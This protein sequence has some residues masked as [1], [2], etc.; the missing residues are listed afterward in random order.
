MEPNEKLLALRIKEGDPTAFEE[1]YSTNYGILHSYILTIIENHFFVEDIIEDVFVTLWEKRSDLEINTSLK[2]YLF[3]I[4]RN[5]C[6]DFIRKRK[7]REEYKSR[8][9]K[10]YIIESNY[11]PFTSEISQDDKNSE[12][13]RVIRS[14]ID[15]L[16]PKCRK[17]FKLSRYFNIKNKEIAH[18]LNISENTVEKHMGTALSRLRQ[19]LEPFFDFFL[20]ITSSIT[21]F[22]N[23]FYKLF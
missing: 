6:L 21:A 12:L 17:V 10:K 8:V 19:K 23:Q 2:G 20:I 7:V 3:T 16:P 15:E 14:A 9:E 4:A 11:N 5:A 1:I 18:M 13:K 22:L